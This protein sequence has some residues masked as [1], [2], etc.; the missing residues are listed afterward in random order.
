MR[1]HTRQ[2]SVVFLSMLAAS[3]LGCNPR[4]PIYRHGGGDL[5]QYLEKATDIEYPDVDMQ[6]LDE[7]TQAHA[8][9]T[10]GDNHF[11]S[12]WDLSLEEALSTALQNNKL[13]RGYGTPGLQE[14][15]VAP[16]VDNM[17]NGAAQ[18]GS[19]YS[20]AIRESEP[21][22]IGTPGQITPPSNIPTNTS[23]D[24]NQGVESALAEFDAQFTSSLF[25]ERTDRPRNTSFDSNNNIFVQ[26]QVNMQ[27]ELAKK[28]A[29]GSQ[30][31]LRNVTSYTRN[32]LPASLQALSS[33]YST[34]LEAEVR[35]PL[36]RGRGTY[37]NRMPVIFARINTDQELANLEAQLQNMLVNVEI[38]YWDLYSAYRNYQ[39]AKEGRD[40]A[41]TTWRL[42]NESMKAGASS[43]P[44][45]AQAREQFFS[46]QAQLK[47]SYSSL[48]DAENDLRWLMG[49]AMTDGRLIRPHDEPTE[50]MIHYN[51][52]DSL[53]EALTF[54][55]SLRQ[56][57]WELKKA[58]LRLAHSRNGLL[59]SLNLTGLYRVVGLGD[60]LISASGSGVNFPGVG[61][62]AWE[63]LSSGDYQEG[64]MGIEF[65]MPV[66][67][68]R[69]LANVRNAQLKL[70]LQIAR[71]ED[72]ELDVTRE[73]TQAM[74]AVNLNYELAED[75]FNQ[76]V[77]ATNQVNSVFAS[78][79]E[80]NVDLKTV[81][82]SQSRRSQAQSGYY[83]ALSE[84]NKALALVHRRKG[85][86]LEYYG[87]SF[88]EGPWPGKAYLDAEQHAIRRAASKEMNYAFSRPEVVSQGTLNGS[89]YS[90]PF[91]AQGD[92]IL[93]EGVPMEMEMGMPM[94]PEMA[95]PL[96]AAQPQMADPQ[97]IPTQGSGMSEPGG[98]QPMPSPQQTV[99]ENNLTQSAPRIRSSQLA[100]TPATQ[101]VLRSSTSN[102][103][104][105]SIQQASF[106][107]TGTATASS[108]RTSQSRTYQ[109]S[110]KTTASL[111]MMN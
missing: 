73:L 101:A 31:F 54:Q 5:S 57:R 72:M 15:R 9:I 68:R 97:S 103:S 98:V 56:E 40:A 86:A 91:A 13:I 107:S 25:W 20:V 96:P 69:E 67:Y 14:S 109:G 49:I 52:C 71:L 83:Q 6:P 59:P 44:D 100:H 34:A 24:V 7:V 50:A 94:T 45:E 21:G 102:A 42:V 47:K 105:G 4:Q 76:W 16:G 84:Y 11:D 82:D 53:D 32:N 111:K 90:A 12:F 33:V 8:P 95:E 62:E 85:T 27:T 89:G 75:R 99:L 110:R 35:Q 70:A 80:G 41:L 17:A 55:P 2:L 46:F 77:A 37:I 10:V 92:Y 43:L 60:D 39:A 26:D 65:G 29:T 61:S 23:L 22:I 81:L 48:L 74:R 87:V 93:E 78:Y 1:W 38:R 3:F 18:A 63:S 79:Q 36:M 66:G 104:Q 51:W 19:M 28:T 108:P 58:Q 106:Q 64:R 88:A 30:F